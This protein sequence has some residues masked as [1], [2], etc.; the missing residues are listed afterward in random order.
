[1]STQFIASQNQASFYMFPL[2]PQK[3]VLRIPICSL[4]L[5]FFPFAECQGKKRADFIF[6]FLFKTV[7]KTRGLFFHENVHLGTRQFSSLSGRNG[8]IKKQEKG[9]M[10]LSNENLESLL[11]LSSSSPSHTNTLC[12]PPQCPHLQQGKFLPV[13]WNYQQY[14]S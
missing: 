13:L 10:V 4:F 1:M 6:K 11:K 3:R 8:F 2:C 12:C 5:L 14:F 7:M 9:K